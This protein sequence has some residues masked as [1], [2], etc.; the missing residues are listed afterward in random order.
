[1]PKAK[2]LWWDYVE[3]TH[4]NP[5]KVCCLLCSHSFPGGGARILDHFVPEARQV[6]SCTGDV[7]R[8]L[9]AQISAHCEAAA[10]KKRL[11]DARDALEDRRQSIT[12]ASGA[13][14]GSGGGIGGGGGGG[15]SG[16]VSS[17]G[18]AATGSGAE[19]TPMGLIRV[20]AGPHMSSA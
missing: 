9:V 12:S 15:G 13:G 11:R 6:K 19:A 10:K 2:G 3:R 1:M 5:L 17:G 4:S 7:P 8:D 18:S 16:G 14:S 20:R